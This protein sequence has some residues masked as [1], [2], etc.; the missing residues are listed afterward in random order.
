MPKN[1]I[2]AVLATC[3]LTSVWCA[4]ATA[5]V[6]LWSVGG[7]TVKEKITIKSK[8]SALK[9]E[10]AKAPLGPTGVECRATDEG[11]VNTEGKGEVSKVTLTEC[12]VVKGTCGGTLAVSAAHLPW[13]TKLQEPSGPDNQDKISGSSGAPGWHVECTIAGVK[14]VDE[15]TGE[16]AYR[17]E[18]VPGGVETVFETE[19]AEALNCS[20]GGAK[21]GSVT[22]TDLYENPAGKELAINDDCVAFE[23]CFEIKNPGGPFTAAGQKRTIEVTNLVAEG[24][25]ASLHIAASR[26]G[27]FSIEEAQVETCRKHFYTLGETCTF[28]VTCIKLTMANERVARLEAIITLGIEPKNKLL[29]NV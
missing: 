17:V 14:V 19:E 28:E 15:C 24:K 8:F 4:T 3:L 16:I 20:Q 5:A 22:G 23:P 25:P 21:Q 12:K 6:P 2:S 9:I 11:S 29:L 27:F 10:D 26:A 13:I 18:T 1:L 7:A